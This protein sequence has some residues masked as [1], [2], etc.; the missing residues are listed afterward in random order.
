MRRC[1]K[2]KLSSTNGNYKT[3]KTV[4]NL[5]LNKENQEKIQTAE[6][7]LQN[8]GRTINEINQLVYAAVAV[9]AGDTVIEP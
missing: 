9:M 7:V 5:K 2:S 6:K 8:I 1:G 3:R 4:N